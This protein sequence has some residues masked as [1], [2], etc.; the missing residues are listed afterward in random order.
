MEG[1]SL[2]KP[3]TTTINK[4]PIGTEHSFQRGLRAT[5]IIMSRDLGWVYTDEMYVE[6]SLCLRG[7]KIQIS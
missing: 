2:F 4:S 3:A 6:S 5:V 1:L 7:S